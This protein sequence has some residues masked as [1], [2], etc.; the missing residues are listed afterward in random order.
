MGPDES[1]RALPVPAAP[2]LHL[3]APAQ[4]APPQSEGVA[5]RVTVKEVAKY[6]TL[7]T[8]LVA[9]LFSPVATHLVDLLLAVVAAGIWHF[10]ALVALVASLS[11]GL[12]LLVSMERRR[13]LTLHETVADRD[14]ELKEVQRLQLLVAELSKKRENE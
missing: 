9:F 5:G 12:A 13:M 2:V 7:P 1:D 6:A 8:L 10:W 4:T 14:R 3:P 11:G